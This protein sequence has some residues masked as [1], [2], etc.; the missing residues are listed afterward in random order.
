MLIFENRLFR[1]FLLIF[2]MTQL[3]F[4]FLVLSAAGLYIRHI[5][6]R[7][8]YATPRQRIDQL[9]S[10]AQGVLDSGGV[11]ALLNWVRDID[12]EELA[13]LLMVD[14]NHRDLL[15]R[16]ISPPTLAYI[17][18]HE[19]LVAQGEPLRPTI[20]LAT[21]VRYRFFYDYQKATLERFLSR[22]KVLAVPLILASVLAAI[23]AY[24]LGIY[25]SRPINILRRAM[26]DFSQ[27]NLQPNVRRHMGQR[28]DELSDLAHALDDMVRQWVKVLESHK[29]LLRDV[30]HD[31]RS[32][33]AR[34][35]VALSLLRKR[36]IA[37]AD[38]TESDIERDV[39]RVEKE[40]ERLNALIGRILQF[41]RLDAGTQKILRVPFDWLSM[42]DSII[43]SAQIEAEQKPCKILWRIH[44]NSEIEKKL[45]QYL[46]DETLW[47]SAVEN[48]LG[49]AIRYTPANSVVSVQLT[50]AKQAL[51]QNI[52]L[53]IEDE[54]RGVDQS[55]LEH[56]FEPFFR[57]DL[58]AT[59]QDVS[60]H[61]SLSGHDG[62]GL[63]IAK[64][65]I[66]LH[67]G[68]IRA[69]NR[70]QGGLGIA[71]TFTLS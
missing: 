66:S 28:R 14:D 6:S 2:W 60:G 56:L 45:Q 43:S 53:T 22:P 58:T 3:I 51:S 21:G 25:F 5:Q 68:T 50:L 34:A 39:E 36:Y 20:F 1:K 35:T 62:L 27:G 44:I 19:D 71:I 33:L 48:V 69:Y 67:Q 24:A 26:R 23:V 63:A 59:T 70:A 40:L 46:G 61:T 47:R 13:P 52:H 41:A 31:L 18:A 64:R 49:N 32:P 57:A 29:N 42:M 7:Y 11:V 17:S 16:D 8:D 54:G 30:S 37:S 12:N 38:G 10:S 15:G 55:L 4:L 65:A 9:V